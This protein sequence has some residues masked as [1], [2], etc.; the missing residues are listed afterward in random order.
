M[1]QS[2]SSDSLSDIIVQQ[3]CGYSFATDEE[4]NKLNNLEYVLPDI[5]CFIEYD[6][7]PNELLDTFKNFKS[8]KISYD[9]KYSY[10]QINDEIKIIKIFEVLFTDDNVKIYFTFCNKKWI[11]TTIIYNSKDYIKN[12]Y[13]PLFKKMDQDIAQMEHDRAIRMINNIVNENK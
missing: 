7:F 13:S 1:R 10:V 5:P 4:L 11:Q 6:C 8:N 2:S 3:Q 9:E 12:V